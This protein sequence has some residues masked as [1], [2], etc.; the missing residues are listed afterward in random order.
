MDKKNLK[1]YNI[2]KPE[3]ARDTALFMLLNINENS[4]KSNVFIRETLDKNVRLDVRDKAL[5]E[6]LVQGTLSQLYGI[7]AVIA[8]YS[9]TPV[10][11]L[12]PYIREILR[13]SVYQLMYMD[14]IP[15][16]AA[17]NEGVELS[18]AHGLIKLSGYVNGV[19][20]SIARD[21]EKIH[22]NG[23]DSRLRRVL[24]DG[25]VRYSVP[26]WLY[27]KLTEDFG[28]PGAEGIFEAWMML[29][30]TPVRFNTSKASEEKI[31]EMIREDGV[32]AEKI[33]AVPPVYELDGLSGM[34]VAGLKA[35]NEG[36]ITVQDAS[37][38]KIAEFVSPR[39]GDYIIDMCAAP[40]GKS[41]LMADMSGDEAVIDSR[42]VSE[43]KTRLIDE[44]VIRCGFKSIKTSV[45]DALKL[46][47]DVIGR[48][49]IVIA[50]LPCSGLG[51]IAKKPDIKKRI[52]P[53][54]ITELR[55]MQ[56]EILKNAV[57]YLKQGGT[58][59]YSTCTVTR[60]ENEENAYWIASE[61]K[62]KMNMMKRI[63]PDLHHDGFFIAGYTKE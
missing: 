45:K 32:S 63:N 16:N 3:S 27:K 31:L 18:K 60:E 57:R 39:P 47:K 42:D 9:K 36:Y 13:M 30:K 21:K 46:D 12:N 62:L 14:R 19:L 8:E 22:M 5:A 44:N 15:D 4:R 48:A 61:L 1:N 59:I 54:D 26:V 7:D 28:V 17:I 51:V 52:T 6:H 34:G 38:A 10:S 41:L 50:D 40:G 33:E 37:A 58:L 25:P 20:R 11:K 29:R 35:F 53:E 23:E 43:D 24:K 56:R 55:D 2:R 49:D